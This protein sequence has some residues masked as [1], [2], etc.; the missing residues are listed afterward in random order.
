M[1]INVCFKF[2][3]NFHFRDL[4]QIS[5]HLIKEHLACYYELQSIKYQPGI[6][7]LLLVLNCTIPVWSDKCLKQNV[8]YFWSFLNQ[9]CAAEIALV[10]VSVCV[11]VCP[12][13]RVLITSGVIWC[14]I[15]RVRLVKQFWRL[16]PAFNY[17]LLWHLSSVEWMGVAILT[18]HVVNACQRKLRR[19]GTSYKRTTW[20]TERFIYKSEWANA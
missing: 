8:T 15:G 2:Q 6:F 9:A 19:C 13:P 7:W 1:I 16:S 20:K 5:L 3:M 11:C 12:P 18:Q 14:D 10:R 4:H 17:F